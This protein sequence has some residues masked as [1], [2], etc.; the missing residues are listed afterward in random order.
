MAG[1][2][3]ATK[4]LQVRRKSNRRKSRLNKRKGTVVC[5]CKKAKGNQHDLI[6]GGRIIKKSQVGSQ[7]SNIRLK[8]TKIM[9]EGTWMLTGGVD[10][11]CKCK[12]VSGGKKEKSRTLKG[13]NMV[14]TKYR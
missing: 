6:M 12:I 9:N 4:K 1:L 5:T 14:I 3:S 13:V 8:K 10:N 7:V 11:P 2:I